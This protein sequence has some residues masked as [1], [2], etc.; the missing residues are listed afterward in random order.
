VAR[1]D[2]RIG[3]A[4]AGRVLLPTAGCAEIIAPGSA[5]GAAGG[6]LETPRLETALP[7][8]LDRPDSGRGVA[9]YPETPHRFRTKRQLWTYGGV[10]IE[11]SSSAD[12]QIIKRQLQGKKKPVEIRGLNCRGDQTRSLRPVLCGIVG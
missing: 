6:E 3:S 8:P 5:A 12:H 7:D 1:E 10:G 4:P 11:T 2:R 9:G